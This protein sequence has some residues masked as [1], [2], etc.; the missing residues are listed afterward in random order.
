[1][2]KAENGV[3]GPVKGKVGNLIFSSWLGTPT[4]RA[5]PGTRKTKNQKEI[6]TRT[7][8]G[9]SWK[10]ILPIKEYLKL[11]FREVTRGDRGQFTARQYLLNNAVER[12]EMNNTSFA[13][14]RMLVS[15]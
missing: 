11:G 15:Q 4:V 5:N 12:D 2:A 7:G 1:M 13:P 8:F 10:Y 6:N 14:S 3:L 9:D